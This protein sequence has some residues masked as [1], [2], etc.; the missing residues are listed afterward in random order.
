MTRVGSFYYFPPQLP[1]N[2]I[3]DKADH[4]AQHI[5]DE[6]ADGILFNY[7]FL[8]SSVGEIKIDQ[9]LV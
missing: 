4:E 3:I 7:L 9:C 8:I 5:A 6:E 1:I 2:P